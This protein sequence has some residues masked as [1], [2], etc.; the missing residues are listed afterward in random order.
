MTNFTWL[1][2]A[3]SFASGNE[4]APKITFFNTSTSCRLKGNGVLGKNMQK[5]PKIQNFFFF[6][7]L[8]LFLYNFLWGLLIIQFHP[9]ILHHKATIFNTKKKFA[10]SFDERNK[11]LGSIWASSLD[12]RAKQSFFAVH[13]V[14]VTVKDGFVRSAGLFL[15]STNEPLFFTP[16]ESFYIDL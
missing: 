1:K 10:S 5:R 3:S 11:K 13:F 14:S 4:A 9:E 8:S 16:K 15:K 7:A 6:S 2:N 12:T